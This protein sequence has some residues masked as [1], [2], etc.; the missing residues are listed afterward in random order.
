M[1][2]DGT[3]VVIE[4]LASWAFDRDA[5]ELPDFAEFAATAATT[6]ILHFCFPW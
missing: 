3:C 4:R 1:T 6:N 5:V 2:R